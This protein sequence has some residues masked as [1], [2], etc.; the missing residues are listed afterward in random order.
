M[1]MPGTARSLT[2]RAGGKE[3]TPTRARRTQDHRPSPRSSGRWGQS[4]TPSKGL[5]QPG[6]PRA[7]RPQNAPAPTQGGA[8]SPPELGRDNRVVMAALE[9]HQLPSLPEIPQ[10]TELLTQLKH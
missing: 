2:V 9:P 7:H 10:P 8:G 3:E 6:Q 4:P 1:V 5:G